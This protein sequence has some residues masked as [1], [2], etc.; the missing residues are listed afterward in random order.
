M[1]DLVILRALQ[2]KAREVD[3]ALELINLSELADPRR[4]GTIGNSKRTAAWVDTKTVYAMARKPWMEERMACE[5]SLRNLTKGA[6][7]K[8]LNN[9]TIG[10][11]LNVV[12]E[13]EAQLGG[14]NTD[15]A[16]DI[17]TRFIDD[18]EQV[19]TKMQEETTCSK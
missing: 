7:R 8:H 12:T 11:V 15:K 10:H 6:D 16:W 3:D 4:V 13:V 19:E 1:I 9:A 18:F 5:T 2:G 17:L 14:G